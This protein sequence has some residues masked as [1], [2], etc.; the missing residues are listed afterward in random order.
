[1]YVSMS[2]GFVKEAHVWVLILSGRAI[3]KTIAKGTVVYASIA[4]SEV[5]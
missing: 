5:R 2:Y 4:A 3:E 1:M